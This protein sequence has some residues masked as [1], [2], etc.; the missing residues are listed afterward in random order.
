M[1]HWADIGRLIDRQ[2]NEWNEPMGIVKMD[3]R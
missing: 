3:Q 2:T 1:P